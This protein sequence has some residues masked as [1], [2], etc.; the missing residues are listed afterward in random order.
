MSA[1]EKLAADEKKPTGLVML[2]GA[3]G[4]VFG[5][6]GTSPLYA[7]KAAL[8]HFQDDGSVI[9]RLEVYG[10][11]SMIFWSLVLI[12]TV[13]YVLLVMRA[14]N[15]GE[16][17]ILSLMAL[18]Q[19]VANPGRMRRW[20]GMTGIIGACLFFGDG[21]ITPAISVLSAVEGLEITYPAMQDYVLP[22]ASVVIVALFMVQWRGTSI[23]GRVFGPIMAVWFLLIGLLGLLAILHHP[24]V[25]LALSP[26]YAGLLL[27]QH[28]LL[29]FI[30]LGSVVLAVT[31][32]EALYADMGHFG[33]RPIKLAW[34]WVVLP[35][36]TLNYFGQGALILHD[37]KALDN[38]FFLL[39]PHWLRL[40]MVLLATAA[41]VIASQ[42]MISGA[43]SMARQ[44]VQLGFLP[45]MTVRHTSE[46]EQGQIYVPQVNSALLVGV[47]ALVLTFRTSD[48]LAAAYG[49]AVTGTFLCTGILAV[50]VFRRQFGWSRRSVIVVFGF[51][52]LLDSLFFAS[53]MLKIPQGGYVPLVL[54][55][56][57]MAM[58]T[59]WSAGRHLL[60]TRWRQDSLPLA[61]FLARLPQSR[62]LRV[63]GTAVFL[64]GNPDY[65]P[66]ALLH[67]L[68]H[69]KVLHE[70]VLFLT[71]K[72]LDQPEA[73]PDQHL[74]VEELAKN[75][76]RVIIR[77]GFKESPNIP[78]DLDALRA[79]GVPVEAMQVSYFF[80]RE[81]IVAGKAPKMPLWR[82]WLFLVMARNA[83][84]ATEFFRIP[85]DR[86][87]ELGVRVPI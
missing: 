11:L 34:L 2:L 54:G 80:G 28:R 66:G 61:S 67:N 65:V 23:M 43:F 55:G 81:T 50:V 46:T 41:T 12:V 58:M 4:V 10:V 40:P 60:M 51:F 6:I 73:G 32:A 62:I 26:G 16:G 48:N 72:T 8:L 44:C 5:D 42:A 83:V 57:L 20:L 56:L 31:G 64:T 22:I 76:Y 71:V 49:I 19:R 30:V 35:A 85:S 69:N 38:P 7:F 18:A 52:F 25:L 59:S 17:G 36:L 53:N 82:L 74:E 78:R 45:R 63:P 37:I 39:T 75:V 15:Q 21:V 47:L 84:P 9:N 13:K 27:I 14:D 29:A 87:V 1:A 86:V 79:R 33:G 70:R 24:K 3:L 77:Y 68:K